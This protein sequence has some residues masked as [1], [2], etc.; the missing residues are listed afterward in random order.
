M[1]KI[2]IKAILFDMDGVL[3]D[4]KEWHYE[5]LN[6]ALKLFGNKISRYEH[7]TA[8][9]GL[10]T[11]TKLHMLSKERGFP[12]QLHEFA[13][14]MKQ[15][16]TMQIVHQKCV[17]N[18][19]HEYA[20]SKLKHIGYKLAVCSNSIRNTVQVMMEKSHLI[21]HLDLLLSNQDIANGK[22]SP[23]IYIKAIKHFN[24]KPE[25]CLIVEDNENGI[26]AAK[27]AKGHLLI[28]QDPSE[29]NFNNIINRIQQIEASTA[30]RVML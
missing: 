10:P 14:E 13:N 23:D 30:Q 24:L 17:P 15:L 11:R 19:A 25:E 21:D 22:P 18:F 6:K 26:K 7:L 29:V 8:F 2:Q 5:A 28:V 1:K 20:L 12:V 16:Y 3:I 27:A 4:A 9:D